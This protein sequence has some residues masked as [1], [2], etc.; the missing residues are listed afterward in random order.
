MLSR[1]GAAE[2]EGNL[3]S[4]HLATWNIKQKEAEKRTVATKLH[5]IVFQRT[6][7]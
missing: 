6:V 1:L 2:S 3:R 7:A 5:A 4:L